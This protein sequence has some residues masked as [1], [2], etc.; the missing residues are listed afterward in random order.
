M[1]SEV[2]S[3]R[4]FLLLAVAILAAPLFASDPSPALKL[5]ATAA[6]A[7]S[8]PSLDCGECLFDEAEARARSLKEHKPLVILVGECKGRGKLVLSAGGIPCIVSDYDRDGKPASTPRIVILKPGETDFTIDA[9]LADK[10]SEDE[11][12]KAVGHAT[13]TTPKT[14]PS[15]SL[16]DWFLLVNP[17]CPT[18]KVK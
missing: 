4:Y 13:P 7:L 6:L 10:A 16:I 1:F 9:T 3:M 8:A 11:I 18:C 15:T 12:R 2:L 14:M 17:N 5:R